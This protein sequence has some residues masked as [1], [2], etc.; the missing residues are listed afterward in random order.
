MGAFLFWYC[1]MPRFFFS[2]DAASGFSHPFQGWDHIVAMIAVGIWAAQMRGQAVWMLPL[3]FVGMMT[4]GGMAGAVSAVPGAES[5]IL[6]SGFTFSLF[7]VRKIKFGSRTN[8]LIVAF[9]AFF[10]GYAH[11]QEISAS[12]SFFSY[13]VGFVTATLILH[14]AGILASRSASV[15]LAFF[16]GTNIHAQEVESVFRDGSES[17][18][19]GKSTAKTASQE[20]IE[21]EDITVLERADSQIG[22]ADSASQGNIGQAQLKYRPLSRPAEVLEAVPGLIATQ[23]SG[24][25]KAN[26]YFLRG[27]NLDHGTDFL[28]QIEGVPINQLSHSHGQGWTDT[29]FLIP[30]LIETLEYKKGGHYAENGDFSST[31]SANIRYFKTLPETIVKFTGGSFDYYRGLIAGSETL[32]GGHLLYAGETVHN[33]GP[34][35]IGNDYLKFNGVLRYSEEH[36]GY[37]WSMTGMASKADW[38]S[39]DQIPRGAVENGLIGRFD[40]L[41]PTDG[42]SSQRYSVTGEWHR[43]DA[44]S[45]TRLMAYGIYNTL[46]LFSDFTF[47]L[48]NNEANTA[49]TLLQDCSRL[50]DM[51]GKGQFDPS[52]FNT[53]G[54]QFGQPDDRWTTGFKGTHTFFHKIGAAESETTAGLQIRNDNIQNMLTKTHAQRQYDITR[55]DTMWVTSISPYAENRTRWNGWLR[56]LIGVRFDGFRFDVGKSSQPANANEIYDGLVS[57][58][59]GF[60][61]G[62]WHD[63]EFY[64][65]GGMGYHSNDARGVNAAVDPA[66]GSPTGAD[67]NPITKA[68]PLVRT[69]SAEIGVRAAW[70]KGLQSTFA[71]W[72]LD[73]DSELLFVGDAGTTE[74]SNPSRRY[75]LEFA[76]YYSP[77][78]WLTFDADF[79]FS[80]A[81]FRNLPDGQ[82]HIPGSV[83]SVLAAGATFHDVWGGLYGGPRL[84][85]FGPRDLEETGRFRSGET[86]LLSA[87]LGY[88][89]NKNLSFQAEVYNI[90]NRQDPGITYYYESRYPD[91]NG[92][93]F[94]GGDF[95]FHPVEPV[96]FRMGFTAR[97]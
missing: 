5:A 75:G 48:D 1:R 9:F 89:V 76:N 25:G 20:V 38:R 39:T 54:D 58:K 7:I 91:N 4:L 11:G 14:G 23:H 97:F 90:L 78:S 13:T 30:E 24:E 22:I 40:A 60:I 59:L 94:Q 46:D 64:L 55:A 16:I 3:A 67:G 96:S 79:S 88:E 45:E 65:N 26:Q 51:P 93:F 69:Y 50:A 62:P 44:E 84:R 92:G 81:R 74:S 73:I 15:L 57:P 33:N 31:G 52:I 85:Y 61:F 72:W 37:G 8:A 29:N 36:E 68:T 82:N 95:H 41:D 87:T 42:G 56:T 32:G 63:T 53:C 28:T 43:Q 83:E 19:S 47:F 70:V 49:K 66:T 10:H 27:F 6:L 86:L 2:A 21:L 18:V 17:K 77:N 71:F 34:W 12:T 80:R 35:T